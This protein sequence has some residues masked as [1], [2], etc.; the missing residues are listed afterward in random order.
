MHGFVDAD[1]RFIYDRQSGQL[2]F[3]ADGNG[4]GEQV[5]VAIFPNQNAITASDFVIAAP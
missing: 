4:A 5:L 2:Y 3:D 1:D